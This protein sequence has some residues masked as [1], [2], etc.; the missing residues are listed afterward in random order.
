MP[1]A[2]DYPAEYAEAVR[3]MGHRGTDLDAL[4]RAC[5]YAYLYAPPPFDRGFR[6]LIDQIEMRKTYALLANP[7]GPEHQ[8]HTHA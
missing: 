1:R 5:A 4:Q 6:L 2:H 8:D 7:N 3:L